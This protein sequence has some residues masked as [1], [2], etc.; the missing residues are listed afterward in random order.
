MGS[1]G[2]AAFVGDGPVRIDGVG[3]ASCDYL[4]CWSARRARS[5]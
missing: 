5:R 4:L 3:I 2:S 1:A